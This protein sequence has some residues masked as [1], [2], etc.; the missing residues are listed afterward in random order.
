MD[1]DI[2]QSRLHSLS[3][4]CKKKIENYYRQSSSTNPNFH[5][6]IPSLSAGKTWQHTLQ[7]RLPVPTPNTSTPTSSFVNSS[8]RII[9][10]P[11][12]PICHVKD[13]VDF[14]ALTMMSLYPPQLLFTPNFSPMNRLGL[15][16]GLGIGQNIEHI[17][18]KDIQKNQEVTVNGKEGNA[19]EKS[20]SSEEPLTIQP[21]SLTQPGLIPLS[22]IS[23]DENESLVESITSSLHSL[24]VNLSPSRM[25]R[26]RTDSDVSIVSERGRTNSTTSSKSKSSNPTLSAVREAQQILLKQWRQTIRDILL[27]KILLDE[28]NMVEADT[29]YENSSC[30]S[31][32]SIKDNG[33]NRIGILDE[34]VISVEKNVKEIKIRSDKFLLHMTKEISDFNPVDYQWNE[35]ACLKR[36]CTGGT[37]SY[38]SSNKSSTIRGGCHTPRSI[39]SSSRVAADSQSHSPKSKDGGGI[40]RIYF[41][42]DEGHGSVG[43]GGVGGVRS[44]IRPNSFRSRHNSI[45]PHDVTTGLDSIQEGTNNGKSE[46][47]LIDSENIE[48]NRMKAAAV[49]VGKRTKGFSSPT[50]TKVRSNSNGGVSFDL[51]AAFSTWNEGGVELSTKEAFIVQIDLCKRIEDVFN[52]VGAVVEVS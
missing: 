47:S 32:N 33:S 8:Y 36:L 25:N 4:T 6:Q 1:E 19:R 20:S 31:Y 48:I 3:G 44:L 38:V 45:L 2:D 16:A 39:V 50:F 17:S 5:P 23:L 27:R 13:A 34:V 28:N 29:T 52:I 42:K 12:V 11:K 18:N 15:S 30:S 9:R 37:P 43:G 40:D 7:F 21:L 14:E 49:N 41:P 24:P 35:T 22:Q 51:S 10:Y 26:P 46:S